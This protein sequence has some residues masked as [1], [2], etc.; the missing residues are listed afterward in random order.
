M[1]EEEESVQSDSCKLGANFSY[2]P[3]SWSSLIIMHRCVLFR[4]A[5]KCGLQFWLWSGSMASIRMLRR[6]G[7]FW[8]WRPCHGCM[9]KKV[10][11]NARIKITSHMDFIGTL[12][13]I[14]AYGF[15]V[16]LFS[17]LHDRVCSSR[18]WPAGMPGAGVFH[19]NVAGPCVQPV[20]HRQLAD[21]SL[22]LFVPLW[23]SALEVFFQNT[24]C[25]PIH[26]ACFKDNN[27]I[28]TL[29]ILC[30][31]FQQIQKAV[32]LCVTGYQTGVLCPSYV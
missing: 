24:P 12:E 3:L 8:Q 25:N 31:I 7:S 2:I 5:Q 13:V 6:S 26:N 15:S 22:W 20:V 4:W 23:L 32:N 1:K 28:I 11:G 30:Y 9:G 27:I 29:F 16:S 14:L 17:A 18:E 19:G 10:K 21:G